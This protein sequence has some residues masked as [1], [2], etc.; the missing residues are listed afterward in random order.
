MAVFL[1]VFFSVNSKSILSFAQA[2][3]LE[4]SLSLSLPFKSES[5][6]A[7]SLFKTYPDLSIYHHL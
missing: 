7:N 2:P 4:S 1:T 5:D 6:H 3:D